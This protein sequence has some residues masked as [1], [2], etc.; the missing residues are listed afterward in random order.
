MNLRL[1]LLILVCSVGLSVWAEEEASDVGKLL[2]AAGVELDV[3]NHEVRVDATVCLTE[4]ILEYIACLPDTF[5]HEAILCMRCKP[6]ML[7]LSLLAI[8]LEP[9][10]IDELGLWRMR[11]RKQ[12][13]VRMNIEVEYEE[14]GKML[15]RDL[16]ELLSDRKNPDKHV[17]D[18]WIFTGSFFARQG[19]RRVY[20][21]DTCGG[22]IGL[23]LE[24]TSV[25]QFGEEMGNPYEDEEAGLE[26]KTDEVPVTG[27]KVKLIFSPARANALVNGKPQAQGQD[28]AQAEK[29]PP[30]DQMPE[31]PKEAPDEDGQE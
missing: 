18:E 7:H 3:K 22:V 25:I 2:N 31:K 21:A 24:A 29:E 11:A 5:E 20:A 19:E 1:A 17:P 26:I 9:C 10:P 14:D 15:R 28:A 27:T 23:G 30:D 8:G 16:N 12:A 6:S 13:K 4:G